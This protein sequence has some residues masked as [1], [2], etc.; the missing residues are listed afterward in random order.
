[1]KSL[2]TKMFLV[3]M[4]LV[5]ALGGSL[6]ALHTL[7]FRTYAEYNDRQLFMEVEDE[8]KSDQVGSINIQKLQRLSY[9]YGIQIDIYDK[10]SGNVVLSALGIQPPYVSGNLGYRPYA[11]SPDFDFSNPENYRFYRVT[12]KEDELQVYVNDLNEQ[13]ALVFYKPVGVIDQNVQA[14]SRF[15]LIMMLLILIPLFII[16]FILIRRQ[17]R[18]IL[19]L[20]KQTERIAQLDFSTR[21]I[22][23]GEDEVAKLGENINIISD[24][25][26]ETIRTLESDVHK[27]TEVDRVRKDFIA[28]ISHDF[29]TPLGLIRGYAESLKYDLVD[30]DEQEAYY[31][32][33]ID[34]SDRM[35][36]LVK[37]LI[38]L[39]QRE[40]HQ[41]KDTFTSIN[42][43]EFIND[44]LLKNKR[45]REDYLFQLKC[46][47]EVHVY[48]DENALTRVMDNFLTNAYNYGVKRTPVILCV[49]REDDHALVSIYNQGSPIAEDQQASIWDSFHKID[50]SRTRGESGNGLGLAINK[51]IILG[52][53]GTYGFENKEGGVEFYF[54]LPLAKD[55]T[56]EGQS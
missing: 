52:H 8:L 51:S 16:M 31:D 14:S 5:I 56:E 15:T 39:M 32:V 55:I 17:V 23:D 48:A 53:G 26:S 13:V 49:R 45:Y 50:R 21:F 4:V 54:T 9:E 35:T 43:C 22:P 38:S 40:L 28:T 47:E 46:M 1:M 12:E 10:H 34:E 7:F 33:I 6:M 25:L 3:M 29:K 20:Q 19:A 36:A 11:L 41:K 18:P 42:L 27:L 24:K 37:D 2:A 30:E 44:I